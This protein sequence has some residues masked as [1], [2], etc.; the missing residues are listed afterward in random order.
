[1]GIDP[2]AAP[3]KGWWCKDLP[4]INLHSKIG[5][6]RDGG[7]ASACMHPAGTEPVSHRIWGIEIGRS[8]AVRETAGASHEV[9]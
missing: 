3:F 9:I 7:L 5:C 8:T 2:V 6:R 4:N 1:M